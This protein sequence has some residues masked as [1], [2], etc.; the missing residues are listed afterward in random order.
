MDEMIHQDVGIGAD[1]VCSMFF[2]ALDLFFVYYVDCSSLFLFFLLQ[3]GVES[4][5]VDGTRDDGVGKV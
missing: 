5:G 3:A 1:N 4:S 2:V